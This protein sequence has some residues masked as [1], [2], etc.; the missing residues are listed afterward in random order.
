M[1]WLLTQ[2]LKAFAY[3]FRTSP[4]ASAHMKEL[5]V[6]QNDKNTVTIYHDKQLGHLPLRPYYQCKNGI[7]TQ[8]LLVEFWSRSYVDKMI[9]DLEK[10]ELSFLDKVIKEVSEYTKHSLLHV[11]DDQNL[12]KL[13]KHMHLSQPENIDTQNLNCIVQQLPLYPAQKDTLLK[14]LRDERNIQAESLNSN[15]LSS[16]NSRL[17]YFGLVSFCDAFFSSY[18]QHSL[19][20]NHHYIVDTFKSMLLNLWVM[21][22]NAAISVPIVEKILRYLLN[23][24]Q[25][26]PHLSALFKTIPTLFALYFSEDHLATAMNLSSLAFVTTVAHMCGEKLGVKY[27]N[28]HKATPEPATN[29]NNRSN[30]KAFIDDEIEVDGRPPA[31]SR[32][33]EPLL[34]S[35]TKKRG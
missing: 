12:N 35:Y 21:D 32:S 5:S 11:N 4:L 29:I 24:N 25:F 9:H 14:L 20:P 3:F 13:H 33:L 1:Q 18:L 7:P 28:S 6:V 17:M 8:D 31:I 16:P 22:P 2:S 19:K 26:S 23:S 27:A 30:T 10:P 15:K 34:R